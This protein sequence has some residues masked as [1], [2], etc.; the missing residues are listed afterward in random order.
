MLTQNKVSG[1][2]RTMPDAAQ[3]LM[4]DLN[5]PSQRRSPEPGLGSWPIDVAGAD[6]RLTTARLMHMSTPD[7][8]DIRA[9]AKDQGMPVS[10]RGRLPKDIVAAYEKTHRRGQAGKKEA[11]TKT[12]ATKPP[13]NKG[14]VG[15]SPTAKI[16]PASQLRPV[17]ASERAKTV[18]QMP[19]S[20]PVDGALERRVA[21]LEEQVLSL[22]QRLDAAVVALTKRGGRT[23]SL[24]RRK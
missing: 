24:P 7:T 22:T 17:S 21:E 5:Q 18:T 4:A 16:A 13:P 3:L 15:K 1:C 2:C 6:M 20:A 9:W 14:A 10:E 23:F 12:N 19:V 8:S 11:S